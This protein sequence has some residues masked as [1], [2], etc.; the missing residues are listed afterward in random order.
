MPL[1]IPQVPLN[2]KRSP[3]PCL[4]DKAQGKYIDSPY[5][6]KQKKTEQEKHEQ[7]VNAA[8]KEW[9]KEQKTVAAPT[10]TASTPDTR[11]NIA[12]SALVM[13]GMSP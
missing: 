6:K 3:S 13:L 2:P 5:S 11:A 7:K 12:V 8:F 1:K 4:Y 10:P 9:K